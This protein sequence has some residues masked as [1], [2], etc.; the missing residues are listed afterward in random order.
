[1]DATTSS[2]NA[3]Q[4]LTLLIIE[5]YKY[6][7]ISLKC[8]DDH[9][10]SIVKQIGQKS[11]F[12]V[13]GLTW[14]GYIVKLVHACMEVR[15]HYIIMKL[16]Y[17]YITLLTALCSRYFHDSS[18]YDQ[19]IPCHDYNTFY[20]RWQLPQRYSGIVPGRKFRDCRFE[21]HYTPIRLYL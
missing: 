15:I 12:N 16:G 5:L 9:Y 1:M 2:H 4:T 10:K 18:L 6:R 11:S 7:P 3:R 17:E 13:L 20:S 14:E 19:F 8:K 21:S